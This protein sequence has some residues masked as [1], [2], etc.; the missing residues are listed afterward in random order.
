MDVGN[1]TTGP[2]VPNWALTSLVVIPICCV[3]GNCLVV[4]AVGR[5][6]ALQTP[7]NYLLVSLAAAD[8]LVGTLVMP[9]GIYLAVSHPLCER[10][11]KS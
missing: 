11:M 4:G 2:L 3:F 9:F 1:L 10:E 8:L 7:T 5:T 6:R